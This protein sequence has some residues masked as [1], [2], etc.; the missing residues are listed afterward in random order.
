MQVADRNDG[1]RHA[2]AN[3][4][5]IS[6]TRVLGPSWPRAGSQ[7]QSH[8]ANIMRDMYVLFES[9]PGGRATDV[10]TS[11]QFIAAQVKHWGECRQVL[12]I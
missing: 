9:N 11:V 2:I 6:A 12:I 1:D 4:G 10:L 3:N 7:K 5:E 8:R